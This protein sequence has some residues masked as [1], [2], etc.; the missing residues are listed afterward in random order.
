MGS[1]CDA[2]W[3]EAK[4][5][6]GRAFSKR[7]TLGQLSLAVVVP[8]VRRGRTCHARYGAQVLI[9]G[10]Q[11]MVSHVLEIEPRHDL[12]KITIERWR[13]AACVNDAR[14]TRRM[15]MIHIHACPD[16][17]NKLF[18]SVPPFWQAGF[19]RCQIAGD[20]VRRT[21]WHERT[22][23]PAASQIGGRIN[24]LWLTKVRVTARKKLVVA[25]PCVVAT[26]AI[27]RCVDKV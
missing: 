8:G 20:N 25:R 17:L 18:K 6:L 9:D 26:V 27:A 15:E 1:G 12:Q 7:V 16:D 24:H 22:E 4:G 2:L 14:R 19:V 21:A 23:I 5:A 3:A 10:A 11:V 13:H